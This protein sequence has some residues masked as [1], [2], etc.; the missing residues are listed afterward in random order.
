MDVFEE[1]KR[2]IV[3][4]NV[5]WIDQALADQPSTFD[6]DARWYLNDVLDA[7]DDV[8]EHAADVRR[9]DERHALR[10]PSAHVRGRQ[11]EGADHGSGNRP[12]GRAVRRRVDEVGH[13]SHSTLRSH[14]EAPTLL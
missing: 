9:A 12:A 1:L 11:T 8:L 13:M 7:P 2:I 4:F 5:E 10:D 3:P 14:R 6:V